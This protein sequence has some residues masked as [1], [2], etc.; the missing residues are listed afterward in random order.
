MKISAGVSAAEVYDTLENQG[1]TE[2]AGEGPSVGLGGG[3]IFAGGHSAA[4]SKLGLASDQILE[5]EGILANGTSFIASPNVNPDIFWFLFGSGAGGTIAYIRNV[6]FKIFKDFSISGA[7]LTLPFKGILSDDE[8]WSLLEIWHSITPKITD[9]GAFAYAF[10]MAGYFELRPVFAP[11]LS[12]AQAVALI[13]PLLDHIDKLKVK[14]LSLRY[15]LTSSSYP[16][17]NR[18]YKGLFPAFGSPGSSSQWTS[19]LIPRAIIEKQPKE[20]IKTFRKLYDEGA[21]MNEAVM[22]PNLKVAKPV[23]ANSVL[24]AWRTASMHLVVPKPYNDSAPFQTNVDART[25]ITERWTSALGELAPASAGGGTHMNEADAEDPHWQESLYGL[26][27]P[28]QLAIKQ[29]Y[30]PS[31]FWYAKTAVG[32]E[33]WG[34]NEQQR[35]CPRRPTRRE[36]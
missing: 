5:V 8:F 21:V 9:A 10:Y 27:Y 33:Y 28:R 23:I 19:R 6:T 24:P 2:L 13:K 25:F 34:E 7:L 35:L 14:H 17:F 16:T 36:L 26:N 30:D 11:E 18:A 29:R 3:Y 12:E 32:S 15:N 20:V 22:N 4:A 1:Y 31:G